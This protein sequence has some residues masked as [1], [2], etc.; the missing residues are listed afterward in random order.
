VDTWTILFWGGCAALA[1][2][3]IY[4]L[5]RIALRLEANGHL[6]YL[7]KK[8]SGGAAGCFVALQRAIEPQIQHVIHVSAESRLH[9][10]AGGA[11]QGDPDAA[12]APRTD[13]DDPSREPRLA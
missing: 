8:P 4:A 12:D 11:G 10:E 5:H 1:A 2:G 6:Y 7:H 3:A 9:G 13:P